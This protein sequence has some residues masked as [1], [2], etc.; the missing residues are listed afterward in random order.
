VDAESLTTRPGTLH[1]DVRRDV[2]H[3]SGDI[4]LAQTVEAG[5][6]IGDRIKIMTVFSVNFAD[7]MQPDSQT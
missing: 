1:N 5:A 2:P 3:L 4:K 7:G 6:W